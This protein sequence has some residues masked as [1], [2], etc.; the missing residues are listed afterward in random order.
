MCHLNSN[1]FTKVIPYDNANLHEHIYNI[2]TPLL[3]ICRTHTH[4][5]EYNPQIEC[6]IQSFECCND[7]VFIKDYRGCFTVSI[8]S[9]TISKSASSYKNTISKMIA[10]DEDNKNK[11]KKFNISRINTTTRKRK[12]LINDC[13]IT[14]VAASSTTAVKKM[15][16]NNGKVK[17]NSSNANMVIEKYTEFIIYD[18]C[19]WREQSY[20]HFMS[21]IRAIISMPEV[22]IERYKR[23]ELSNFTISNIKKYKS[24][25]VSIIRTAVTGFNTRGI[26]Q[27]STISFTT[28]YHVVVIPSKLYDLLESQQ[29]DMRLSCVIRHPSLLPTCMYISN[30]IRNPN[31]NEQVIKISSETSKGYNQDQDG[32]KNPVNLLRKIVDG[33]QATSSFK[34]FLA[35]LE[36]AH[37]FCRKMTLIAAPRY[38]FSETTL[39]YLERYRKLLCERSEVFRKYHRYGSRFLN[40][41]LAGYELDAYAD[42]Q[43]LLI[44]TSVNEPWS[45][46]TVN[47]LLLK[48]DRLPSIIR[49]GA[50]GTK[51][52]LKL[53]LSKISSTDTLFDLKKDLI[54]LY[55]KYVISSQD[56]S[57]DGRK[58][59]TCNYASIDMVNENNFIYVNKIVYADYSDFASAILLNINNSS[60][61]AF[62]L[63][64]E[65]NY[66]EYIKNKGIENEKRKLSDI[67]IDGGDGS[68]NSDRIDLINNQINYNN[69]RLKNLMYDEFLEQLDRCTDDQERNLIDNVNDLIEKYTNQFYFVVYYLLTLIQIN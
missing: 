37:A 15:K 6:I 61:F 49:S 69:E 20:N 64:L 1:I 8:N 13:D 16:L 14:T 65:N 58:Q 24:G 39:L 45:F 68:S 41:I 7:A 29:Y 23:F 33:Y 3:Y 19:I 62:V 10:G 43:Q 35:K 34:Y 53:F 11:R 60:I 52:L 54:E 46:V 9:T 5:H 47:D 4:R 22:I 57:R 2:K 26:Y 28:P 66:N 63:D 42:F 67:N 17:V 25:K 12:K 31:E 36:L 48:T 56:L 30:V 18:P 21:F 38:L 59:F 51:Y 40:E 27:T 32:D 44:D 55:N 50:K